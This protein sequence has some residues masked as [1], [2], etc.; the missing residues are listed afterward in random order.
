MENTFINTIPDEDGIVRQPPSLNFL[1]LFLLG[2]I[3]YFRPEVSMEEKWKALRFLWRIQDKKEKKL[4]ELFLKKIKYESF[5]Q[6][7]YW[8]VISW[9]VKKLANFRCK[10][11]NSPDN[12]NTHHRSYTY[13]GLEHRHLKDLICICNK[14]HELFHNIKHGRIYE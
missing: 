8:Q 12:L 14:C 7:L 5:L 11:C 3:Y 9:K 13:H 1:L 6:T 10:I 4:S 2:E